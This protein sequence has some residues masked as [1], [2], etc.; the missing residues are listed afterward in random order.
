MYK[1]DIGVYSTSFNID[2][3]GNDKKYLLDLGTVY[4]DVEVFLNGKDDGKK[5]WLPF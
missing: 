1:S 4:Y 2:N 3:I 5:I